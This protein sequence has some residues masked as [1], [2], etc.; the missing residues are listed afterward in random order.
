MSAT[1]TIPQG[2]QTISWI[3][4][5]PLTPEQLAD[6]RVDQIKRNDDGPSTVFT[7]D[8]CSQAPTCTL[9]FDAYNTNGDCLLDK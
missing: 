3:R 5:K 8:G 1:P 9:A 4:P 2:T 7:C 6:Y